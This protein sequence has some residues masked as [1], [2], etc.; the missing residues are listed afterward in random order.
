MYASFGKSI[1][2]AEYALISDKTI[3]YTIDTLQ[4]IFNPR[5]AVLQAFSHARRSLSDVH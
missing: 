4:T 2:Y 5:F 1:L 3:N